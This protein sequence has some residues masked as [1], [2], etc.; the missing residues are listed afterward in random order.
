MRT[1]DVGVM[2]VVMVGVCMSGKAN[3]GGRI[4]QSISFLHR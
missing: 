3:A 1:L 4:G 2:V